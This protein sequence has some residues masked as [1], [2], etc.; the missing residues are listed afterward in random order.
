M[1]CYALVIV[2][3]AFNAMQIIKASMLTVATNC[4]RS[5]ERRISH[6]FCAVH[7]ARHESIRR[8]FG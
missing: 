3:Y 4:P 6:H 1:I 8:V 2:C 5:V 7:V